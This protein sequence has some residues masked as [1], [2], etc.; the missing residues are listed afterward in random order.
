MLVANEFKVDKNTEMCAA[1]PPLEANTT[2]CPLAVTEG[3]GCSVDDPTSNMCLDFIDVKRAY[4]H[5]EVENDMFG[6]LGLLNQEC[7]DS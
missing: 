5:A 6:R 1:T 2:L 4:F 7:A 3:I